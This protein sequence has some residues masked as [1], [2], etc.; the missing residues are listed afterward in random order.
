MIERLSEV[1]GSIPVEP[2]P[3]SR[4]HYRYISSVTPRSLVSRA[5]CGDIAIVSLV[6]VPDRKAM[7]FFQN[8]IKTHEG[9]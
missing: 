4:F 9:K 7:T 1:P 8:N 5:H 3:R 2:V 6:K